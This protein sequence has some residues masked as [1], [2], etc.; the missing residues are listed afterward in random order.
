[1][2][3]FVNDARVQRLKP[4][5]TPQQAGYP[6]RKAQTRVAVWARDGAQAQVARRVLEE[7]GKHELV[8]VLP[9]STWYEA[10]SYHQD[11]LAEDKAF[12]DWSVH[13]DDESGDADEWGS[14]SG[15]GTAWGL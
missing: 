14:L 2:Q 8:P 3:I 5:R 7:A 12:P 10:E 6:F 15:P 11:F 4:P 1:M 9:P 13:P